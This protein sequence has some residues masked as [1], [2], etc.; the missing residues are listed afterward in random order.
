VINFLFGKLPVPVFDLQIAKKIMNKKAEIKLNITDLLNRTANF[1]YDYNTN[2][3]YDKGTDPLA[4]D[5]KFGQTFNISFS[6]NIK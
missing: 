5:R 2:N 3:K 6:Y 4:I 1:Y